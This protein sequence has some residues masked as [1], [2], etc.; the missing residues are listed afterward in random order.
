M[1]YFILLFVIL[2]LSFPAQADDEKRDLAI[3]IGAGLLMMGIEALSENAQANQTENASEDIKPASANAQTVS[4][5]KPKL[6]YDVD[7]AKLQKYLKTLGYYDSTAD[8]LKGKGTLSALHQ[9]QADNNL[10]IS[11]SVSQSDLI[12]AEQQAQ[13]KTKQLVKNKKLETDNAELIKIYSSLYQI[14]GMYENCVEFQ[15]SSHHLATRIDGDLQKN[16][17]NTRTRFLQEAKKLEECRNIS[18]EQSA[19]IQSKA[20]KK[21][22]KSDIGELIALQ[23]R[24]G[25]HL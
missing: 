1:K 20:K 14:E 25:A 3:G 9:W 19:V 12:L 4:P 16:F 6:T 8:G 13:K 21:F 10:N 7:V 18:D 2:C 22:D 15:E 5:S 24:M 17:K 23:K 11:D